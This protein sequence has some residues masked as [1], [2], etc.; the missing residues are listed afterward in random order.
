MINSIEI[1][2]SFITAF[3]VCFF[4]IPSIIKVSHLK[5]LHD[6]PD[7]DRKIHQNSIPNL[8]GLAIFAGLIFSATFWA[9]SLEWKDLQY[10]INALLIL[11]FIGLKDDLVKLSAPKKL[12]GQILA[13]IIIIFFTDLKFTSFY[14]LFGIFDIPYYVS[15]TI[16]LFFIV[17]VTN[18]FNLIDGID[19]LAAMLGIMTCAS[20]GIWFY[21]AQYHHYSLLAFCLSGSLLAFLYFNWSPA[22]IFMG[23]TGSLILGLSSAIMA[24]KFIESN[25]FLSSHEYYKVYSSPAVAAGILMVPILDTI[26]VFFERI[27]NRRSPFYPDKRHLHHLALGKGWSHVKSSLIITGYN[28]LIILMVFNLQ[29]KQGELTLGIILL[30]YVFFVYYLKRK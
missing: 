18:A 15:W 27:I 9:N 7:E 4:A 2:L 1:F 14:G 25:R 23:D 3:L 6:D 10:I 16:T 24:I 12:L 30:F 20:F 21:L 17:G 8:G 5:N 28:S 19:T 11:F 13:A 26:R 29:L 22:K